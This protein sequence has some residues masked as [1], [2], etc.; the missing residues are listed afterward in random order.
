MVQK[1][2]AKL[3]CNEDCEAFKAKQKKLLSEEDEMKKR[4]EL[5]AQQVSQTWLTSPRTL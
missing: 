5:Q 4:E 2:E 3:L 1:G